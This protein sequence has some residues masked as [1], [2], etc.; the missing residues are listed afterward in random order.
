MKIWKF[1]K[2]KDKEEKKHKEGLQFDNLESTSMHIQAGQFCQI[3]SS[4]QDCSKIKSQGFQS[5]CICQKKSLPTTNR[6]WLKRCITK[7]AIGNN[8]QYFTWCFFSKKI[9][10]LIAYYYTAPILNLT[11]GIS[12]RFKPGRWIIPPPCTEPSQFS[13]PLS[14]PIISSIHD[15]P[16]FGDLTRFLCIP[17]K[18]DQLDME[19]V[20][21]KLKKIHIQ[22]GNIRSS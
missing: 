6:L 8:G 7:A 18:I 22:N 21:W 19:E 4:L 14:R 20:I 12:Y 13:E 5:L 11:Q 17:H 1:S 10:P 2:K 3:L 9:L 16:Y 15:L